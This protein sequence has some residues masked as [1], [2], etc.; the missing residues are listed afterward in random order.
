MSGDAHACC[1][2]T[3]FEAVWAGGL[4]VSDAGVVASALTEAGLAGEQLVARANE[5]ATKALLCQRTADA[6]ARGVFGIPMF[7]IDDALYWGYDDLP[8]LEMH[9]RGEDPLA[10][11]DL[12]PWLDVRASVQRKR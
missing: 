11:A 10:G 2:K 4:D 8:I 12:S 1:V 7:T 3:L 5:D 9:L 6:V